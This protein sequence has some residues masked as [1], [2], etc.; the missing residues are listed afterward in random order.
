METGSLRRSL[1]PCARKLVGQTL[2]CGA[3]TL[4][5][6]LLATMASAQ[7]GGGNATGRFFLG[8][9]RWSPTLMLREAGI[10]GNV[11]N[12]PATQTPSEDRYAIFQ[13]QVDG[14]LALGLAEVTAQASATVTY[15][16][17][18]KNERS[19]GYRG[20]VRAEFPVRLRPAV[21]ATYLRSK[22][23]SGNELD[24]RAPFSQS[25]MTLGVTSRVTNRAALQINGS[26]TLVEYDKGVAFAGE[27][28]SEQLNRETTAVQGTLRIDISGLTF[29]LI[30]A[31]GSRD[32]FVETPNRQTDSFR[33]SIGLEFAPDAVIRGRASLGYQ[34]Q[35]TRGQGGF[36]YDGLTAAVDLSYALLDRTRFDGRFARGTNYS[37]LTGEAYYLS[38]AYGLEIT[39]NLIGPLDV[40]ARGSRERLDYSLTPGGVGGRVDLSDTFG[41]GVAVRLT[42]QVRTSLNYEVSERASSVGI[43]NGFFR[44]RLFAT[45]SVGL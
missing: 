16:E 38:T 35:V 33:T 26:R 5:V 42:Q 12:V 9:F 6:L 2:R 30:D 41:G 15:F 21:G 32:I 44:R 4:G 17:K 39:H 14:T 45:F 36:P 31:T 37:V 10:D 8:P 25:S 40:I 22:E 19:T 43:E 23:R 11:F 3:V 13:P 7:T 1:R 27:Q 20:L 28:I 18:Y 34:K 24:V 29:L